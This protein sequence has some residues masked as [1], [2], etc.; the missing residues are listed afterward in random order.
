MTAR[1][2]E[3]ILTTSLGLQAG[4]RV[5]VMC[6][7]PLLA[8]GEALA[9]LAR[10]K[11]TADVRL[12]R[13][14]EPGVMFAVVDG[15]FVQAVREADVLIS[16]R[17]HLDLFEE[18]A[19]IRAAMSAF[20]Q[21]GRARW[22]SLAQVDDEVLYGELSADFGAIAAEATCLAEEMRMGT[23]VHLTS[24]AGSD[25]TLSYEGRPIHVE[26]GMLRT[27]GSIGNLPA[28]EVFVAP[29]ESSAEGRLVVDL[30]LGDLWLDQPVTL[31]FERGRV[32]RAEGG[33]TAHELRS[34]LGDDPW[35][36]TI[37][38]FGLGANPHVTLRGRVAID[39]KALGTAHIALGSNLSFG[40]D[41]PA[42]THYDCVVAR[43]QV[44]IT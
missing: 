13:L 8:A 4:E 23:R 17:S 11:G 29:L 26:T 2:I 7:Q 20:R 10:Q 36:W 41:N 27:P 12:V 44:K 9:A 18:D 31:T 5:V 6:D 39:E 22:A 15:A 1:W 25:L 14:P 32:V 24:E 40:G 42:E 34:R 21:V 38:E 43:A 19:H 33:W 30:C 16:M 3:N 35:A 28:G 37:A